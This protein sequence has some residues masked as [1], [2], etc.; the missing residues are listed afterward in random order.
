MQ[1]VLR[2]IEQGEFLQKLQKEIDLEHFTR[3]PCYKTILEALR[4]SKILEMATK[5]EQGTVSWFNERKM[6]ITGK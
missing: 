4:S 6:T 5:H 1:D 3:K 2:H